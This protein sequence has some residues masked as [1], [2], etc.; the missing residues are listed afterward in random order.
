MPDRS[1]VRRVT[2]D[3]TDQTDRTTSHA[4]YRTLAHRR[5]RLVLAAVLLLVD[6]VLLARRVR[7]YR[8]AYQ[9]AYVAAWVVACDEA[10]GRGRRR[11]RHRP[12]TADR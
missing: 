3:Q 6:A 9:D 4:A 5:R 8:A 2:D 12:A 11:E 7:A 1:T 10:V